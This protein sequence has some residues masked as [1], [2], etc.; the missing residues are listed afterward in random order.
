LRGW[1]FDKHVDYNNPYIVSIRTNYI[2]TPVCNVTRLLMAL[3][4]WTDV[5]KTHKQNCYRRRT[6]IRHPA[7]LFILSKRKCT[8]IFATYTKPTNKRHVEPNV[9]VE[10]H[11]VVPDELIRQVSIVSVDQ[12]E[13]LIRIRNEF[14]STVRVYAQIVEDSL[15]FGNRKTATVSM[16]IPNPVDRSPLCPSFR[17]TRLTMNNTSFR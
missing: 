11:R 14:K 16:S 7:P 4:V 8:I 10:F 15:M 5:F 17:R 9:Y 13:L 12:G 2:R 1:F 6:T 3:L